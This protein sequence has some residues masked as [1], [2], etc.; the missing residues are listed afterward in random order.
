MTQADLSSTRRIVDAP[1]AAGARLADIDTPALLV[2]LDAFEH[3]LARVH[4]RIAAAGLRV[5]PHAKAHKTPAIARRQ[6]A[7]GAH[8]ICCQKTSEAEAFADAGVD[9]ILVTNQIVGEAKVRRAA[10]LARRIRL[11]VCADDPVPVAQL[12]AAARAEGSTVEVL[13]EVDIGHGRCGVVSDAQALAVARA[14]VAAGPQLRFGGIHAFRGTA[15]H[16]RDPAER[17]A[18]VAA[19]TVQLRRTIA[20][21][22]AEG[23]TCA[24]VTGGGTGTYPFESDSGVYTEVQP[25]SYVLL[26]T[27]YA[28]NRPEP[29]AVALRQALFGWCSVVSVRPGQAVL[30]GG[31]KAF[32]VD[33][34][35]PAIDRPGWSIQSL[36]DEHAVAVVDSDAAV[37]AA[38]L[39]VGDKVRLVP[40]HCDPTVNLHD[41]LV[42]VR[43]GRVAEVW[44]VAARGRLL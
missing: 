17:A 23:I 1:A 29:G 22:A 42:A 40:G 16:L 28:A 34:G 30:D 5:R 26:D 12:A 37:A 24:T 14:I 44:P 9:D 8:G 4:T 18:A 43:G 6:L 36:S 39:V 31:L 15:Q 11:A 2:D 41:W 35:L 19:A 7:A 3:N 32:A 13:L 27:D 38:P 10:R 25:G 20:L 21:L 33:Q